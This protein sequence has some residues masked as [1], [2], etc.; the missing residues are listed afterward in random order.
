[1]EP[2]LMKHNAGR[3]LRHWQGIEGQVAS[4]PKSLQA[5]EIMETISIVRR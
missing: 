4:A 1:M 3:N 2:S 5:T